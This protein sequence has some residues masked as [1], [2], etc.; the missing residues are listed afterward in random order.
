MLAEF[1]L[2]PSTKYSLRWKYS[3]LHLLVHVHILGLFLFG[4]C[5]CVSACA[6][7]GDFSFWYVCLLVLV[8]ILGLFLFAVC[9]CVCVLV[10]ILGLFLFAVC[11]RVNAHVR[12]RAQ[13]YDEVGGKELKCDFKSVPVSLKLNDFY[14][15]ANWSPLY[16][17]KNIR[18]NTF[19]ISDPFVHILPLSK[20]LRKNLWKD[21]ALSAACHQIA[22]VF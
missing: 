22:L 11:V 6:Y 10:R 3:K 15:P 21:T 20:T 8:R 1:A 12:A 2:L 9:V 18:N 13:G 19:E 4:V 17:S 16:S 7:F 5:V 14:F